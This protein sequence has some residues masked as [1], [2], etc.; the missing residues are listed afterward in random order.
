[1]SQ[2]TSEYHRLSAAAKEA[3]H[4][5][6]MREPAIQCPRCGTSTTVVDLP[7]HRQTTCP[8]RREPHPLSE[9]ISWGQALELGV[10]PGTLSRWVRRGEVRARGPRRRREYLRLDVTLM[11]AR[12]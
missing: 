2:R 1:M 10:P 4:R 8:G 7:R 12:R 3:R 9:W 6:R 5:D 11:L